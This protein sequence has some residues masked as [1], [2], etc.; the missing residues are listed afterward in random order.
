MNPL[1]FEA[2][3]APAWSALQAGLDRLDGVKAY[4]W[5]QQAGA[6]LTSDAELARLY[7]AACEHL[8]MARA[9]DYPPHITERLEQL[10][11]RAHQRV[12]HRVGSPFGRLASVLLVE[13]PCAVRAQRWY[14]LVALLAFALPLVGTAISAALQ[15]DF[16]LMVHDAPTLRRF[17]QMYGHAEHSGLGRGAEFDF[18]MLGHYVINNIGIAFRTFAAGL[19][20]GVGAILVLVFNGLYAGTIAGHLGARGLG[21]NFYAFVVT[22]GAFELTAIV[23]AGAAGLALGHSLLSPGRRTRLAALQHTAL[24]LV[25]VMYGVFA[26]LV[27]AAVVEAFWSPARWVPHEVKYAVGAVCWV[28]VLAWLM[29]QGRPRSKRDAR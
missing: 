11:Q 7:R 8:A 16:A 29:L 20:F 10:T 9:R 5:E 13:I 15:P 24:T 12:Y 28:L 6:P 21:G 3:Y 17:E 18:M 1:Q 2:Q 4:R 22:H 25:P 26:L 27:V 23:L 14:V 19:F